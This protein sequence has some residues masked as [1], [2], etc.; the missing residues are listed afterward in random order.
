MGSAF[1]DRL[2][3]AGIALAQTAKPP[4]PS[5]I[6]PGCISFLAAA[7]ASPRND[8]DVPVGSLRRTAD[9]TLTDVSRPM[10][11]NGRHIEPYQPLGSV[12]R[13]YCLKQLRAYSVWALM[14]TKTP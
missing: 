9:R 13:P 12:R 10:M 2:R 11:W 8:F 6:S 14:V 7:T 3:A 5:S 1:S 4:S